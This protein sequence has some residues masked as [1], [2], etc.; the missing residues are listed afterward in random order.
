M[1]TFSGTGFK[2]VWDDH[3]YTIT[4]PDLNK[5]VFSQLL[6]VTVKGTAY[7]LVHRHEDKGNGHGAWESL[8]EWYDGNAVK[9]KMVEELCH[10][11]ENLHLHPG[12]EASDYIFKFLKLKKELEQIPEELMT[13]N[14]SLYIFLCNITNLAYDTTIKLIHQQGSRVKLDDTVNLIG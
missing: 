1:S 3:L 13:D 5:I 14:H 10:H 11:F 12:G 9:Y 6:L 2:Q 7:H 8:K 4:H